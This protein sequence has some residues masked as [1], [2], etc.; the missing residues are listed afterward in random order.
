MKEALAK[1]S[2]FIAKQ[3]Y[4]LGVP[5]AGGK[6]L[7]TT[8]LGD[9]AGAVATAANLLR[10]AHDYDK[11]SIKDQRLM[12]AHLIAEE[13]AE[14][15][16]AMA[17]ENIVAVADAIGDLAYVV[18]GAAVCYGLP[19]VELFDEVHASNMTKETGAGVHPKG[20]DYLPPNIVDGES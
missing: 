16:R 9:C 5:L 13:L 14:L 12:R 18:V 7:E 11:S 4:A 1:V 10:Q 2:E 6:S 17:D 20:E 3:G 15:M 19:L 8:I